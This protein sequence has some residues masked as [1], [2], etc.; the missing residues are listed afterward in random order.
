MCGGVWVSSTTQGQG[1]GGLGSLKSGQWAAEARGRAA[2]AAP[3]QPGPLRPL[4]PPWAV[5]SNVEW[6][7]LGSRAHEELLNLPIA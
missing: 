3:A 5:Q 2:P 7:F 1:H 6:S 4:P